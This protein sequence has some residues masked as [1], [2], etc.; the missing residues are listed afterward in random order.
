MYMQKQVG[1]R[2]A[3]EIQCLGM[4]KRETESRDTSKYTVGNRAVFA[5]RIY[6]DFHGLPWNRVFQFRCGSDTLF[7]AF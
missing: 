7:V 3:I 6:S 4:G 1:G 5:R 2:R